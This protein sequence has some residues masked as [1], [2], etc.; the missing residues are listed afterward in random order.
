MR[1]TFGA[2]PPN[3]GGNIM[4][5]D[6]TNGQGQ[7]GRDISPRERLLH[8]S[9]TAG[10]VSPPQG[11]PS[12]TQGRREEWEQPLDEAFAHLE[13]VMEEAMSVWRS[14]VSPPYP[15]Y[16][17]DSNSSRSDLLNSYNTNEAD[18]SSYIVV[19]SNQSPPIIISPNS[20][21]R[22]IEIVVKDGRDIFDHATD[23]SHTVEKDLFDST[24]RGNMGG[25][26]GNLHAILA[27]FFPDIDQ[28]PL[29]H[30]LDAAPEHAISPSPPLLPLT[31]TSEY[32]PCQHEPNVLSFL[33][34]D[35][36]LL[37]LL[38][39]LRSLCLHAHCDIL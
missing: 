14:A 29:L 31:T 4:G 1:F 19:H 30:P 6:T 22:T 28:N 16:S 8:A 25:M 39:P 20:D 12:S 37:L 17:S 35:L 13:A 24:L 5:D 34:S 32:T 36:F 23:S 2:Q 33:S 10:W 38:L 9:N 18:D 3:A 27:S 26:L 15:P 21:S 11:A 7:S